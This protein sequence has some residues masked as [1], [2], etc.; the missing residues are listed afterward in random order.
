MTSVTPTDARQVDDVA[1]LFKVP[2]ADVPVRVEQLARDVA[3]QAHRLSEK[4]SA[5]TGSLIERIDQLQN[6]AKRLRKIEES[7]QA[8]A[9]AGA[10]DEVLASAKDIA[11]VAVIAAVVPNMDGKAL[12]TLLDAVRA[13]KPSLCV[14]LGSVAEGKVALIIGVS[15]DLIAR[16][17]HAGQMIGK[18]APMVGG[19]GGGKADMAQ[20]GGTQA[21]Q[22]AN[23]MTSVHSMVSE[24][25]AS[26]SGTKG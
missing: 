26:A 20:A 15:A 25:L 4:L 12:R 11:G 8:Q 5:R 23:A 13:K 2:F 3:E 6:D 14:V 24:V 21:D 18:L 1:R 9:A 7:R 16:G 22:L 19:R 10:A 17:L